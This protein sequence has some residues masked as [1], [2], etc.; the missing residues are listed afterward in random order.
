MRSLA[1]TNSSK[2]EN[3]LAACLPGLTSGSDARAVLAWARLLNDSPD[4]GERL[5]ALRLDL[6]EQAGDLANDDLDLPMVAVSIADSRSDM[7][8]PGMGAVLA[9]EFLRNLHWP[10]YKPDRHVIRLVRRWASEVVAAQQPRVEALMKALGRRSKDVRAFLEVSL[11][12]LR[13]T[14]PG[15]DPSQADNLIWALGA[16][17]EKKGAETNTRYLTTS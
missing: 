12:A 17:V 15:T 5:E 14:P 9:A 6:R 1:A 16:M 11:A 7:K 3:E 2:L 10:G 8:A 4:W 13:L